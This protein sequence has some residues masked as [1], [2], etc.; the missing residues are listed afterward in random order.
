MLAA[1]KDISKL[2]LVKRRKKAK[3]PPYQHAKIPEDY[4]ELI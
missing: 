3:F 2:H 4:L 1:S